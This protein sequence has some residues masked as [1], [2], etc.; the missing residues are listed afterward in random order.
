MMQSGESTNAKLI[1]DVTSFLGTSGL[2]EDSLLVEILDADDPTQTFDIDDPD[3]DL[4]LFVVRV[5]LMFSDV[6]YSPVSAAYDYPLVAE[7][8]FRNGR[9]TLSE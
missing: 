5:S 8:T 6:S 7:I 9:A 1:D 3:N 4:R 2:P